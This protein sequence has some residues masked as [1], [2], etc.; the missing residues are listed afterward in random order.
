[1]SKYNILVLAI[2]VLLLGYI[3]YFAV[4]QTSLLKFKQQKAT[5]S[6]IPIPTPTSVPATPSFSNDSPDKVAAFFYTAY[7][8]C[9]KAGVNANTQLTLTQYCETNTGLT[10]ADFK[11]LVLQQKPNLSQDPVFCA[12]NPP[13]N[14]RDDLK[15][16]K[17]DIIDNNNATSQ[18]IEIYDNKQTII[19]FSLQKDSINQWRVAKITCE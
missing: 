9:M 11:T 10:N 14:L 12:Q 6:T 8:N 5:T 2:T 16:G 19:T 4:S 18:I 1:M 15:T 13:T 3:T 17:T 7:Q